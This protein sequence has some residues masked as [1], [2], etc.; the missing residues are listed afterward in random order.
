MPLLRLFLLSCITGLTGG[1]FGVVKCCKIGSVLSNGNGCVPNTDT[2]RWPE[3]RYS[4]M[5]TSF[6]QLGRRS[7]LR[8]G[9]QVECQQHLDQFYPDTHEFKYLTDDGVFIS[10]LKYYLPGDYCV[11]VMLHEDDYDYQDQEGSTRKKEKNRRKRKE[12]FS[13]VFLYCFADGKD[14]QECGEEELECLDRCCKA[15]QVFDVATNSCKV[16]QDSYRFLVTK[17]PRPWHGQMYSYAPINCENKENS[18]L[19]KLENFTLKSSILHSEDLL[20]E[21][22]EYCLDRDVAYACLQN[23]DIKEDVKKKTSTDNTRNQLSAKDFLLKKI[24]DVE[25]AKEIIKAKASDQARQ[26]KSPAVPPTGHSFQV[27]SLV[28]GAAAVESLAWLGLLGI[29]ILLE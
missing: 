5:V 12:D 19:T 14:T 18:K 23:E 21:K 20:L 2:D 25:S 1:T 26:P 22:G 17:E 11:D 9:Y 28:N 8:A 29:G 24:N 3:I 10:E 4:D 13:L 15:W 6:T 27:I 7:L 16:I